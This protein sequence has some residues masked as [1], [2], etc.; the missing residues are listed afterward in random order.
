MQTLTFYVN[1]E[2]TLGAVRDYANA[3]N[4]AAPTL[5]RGVSACLKMRVFANAD[6]A[7]PYPLAELSSIPTWQFVMDDD[8]D[9]TSKYVLVAEHSEISVQSI[10]ETI[11][12]VEF[13]FSEFSI[14]IRSMNTEELN[15]LLGT[16][17]SVATLNGE[18]VGF[19]EAGNEVFVLQIK[20]FTV[21]NRISSTGNPTEIQSEYLN[22]A[23]VRA[24]CSAGLELI[25]S[26][27]Q[28]ELSQDWHEVQTPQDRFFRMRLN[29]D[30]RIWS[31]GSAASA[32]WS[33]CYGML[34]GAKGD[35]GQ[36]AETWFTHVVFATAAD[37]TGFIQDVTDWTNNHKYLAV[38]T[39]TKP[40]ESLVAGDLAGLWIKFIIDSADNIKI[41]DKGSYFASDN[42]EAALQ[43]LGNILFGLEEFLKEV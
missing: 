30:A 1:A 34:T 25:F 3:Q 7:D 41:A 9:S 22:E 10:T 31:S 32:G 28:S 4:A 12:E 16:Q 40:A 37:G 27:T 26:E 18:L 6:N 20:G 29:G 13:T 21:R 36:D 24:L 33:D 14:P 8:F 35:P 39:T 2:S 38:L 42:V 5:T 11:N 15:T 23:Q 43:E 17:E 19:D